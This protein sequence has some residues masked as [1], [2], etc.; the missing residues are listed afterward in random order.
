MSMDKIIWLLCIGG[1][2]AAFTGIGIYAFRR[3]EPMFFWQGKT[4]RREELTDTEAYNRANGILW[5][6]YS[7]PMWVAMVL[8]FW[9]PMAAVCIVGL[10]GTIGLGALIYAYQRIFR[11]YRRFHE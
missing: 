9:Y 2:A 5:I 7:V 8:Y 11:K 6:V 1:C 4:I 10:S 3:K